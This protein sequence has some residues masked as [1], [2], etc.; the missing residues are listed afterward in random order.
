MFIWVICIPEKILFY[1]ECSLSLNISSEFLNESYPKDLL[2]NQQINVSAIIKS[3]CI[4]NYTLTYQWRI[5]KL[6]SSGNDTEIQIPYNPSL[7]SLNLKIPKDTLFYGIYK[8]RLEANLTVDTGYIKNITN[9]FSN[10]IDALVRIL[11]SGMDIF[12]L[13]NYLDSIKIGQNQ[14]LEFQP[15]LYSYDY[16][17][18]AKYDSVKFNFYCY[19]RNKSENLT[20]L[21]IKNFSL[22]HDIYNYSTRLTLNSE[23]FTETNQFELNPGN[24]VLK[25]LSGGL[26]YRSRRIY[27][28]LT[29]LNY[30]GVQF[31]QFVKVDVVPAP[32]APRLRLECKIP[33]LCIPSFRS[34]RVNPENQLAIASNCFDGCQGSINIIYT[35]DIYM[36][37]S[38]FGGSWQ[39][40]SQTIKTKYLYGLNGKE[41]VISKGFFDEYPNFFYWKIELMMLALYDIEGDYIDVNTRMLISTIQKPYNGSCSI[42]PNEGF[43][44][45]TD[46]SIECSN[47][48]DT[49]GFIADYS[50]Y[51]VINSSS[52]ELQIPLGS[53]S[54][55]MLKLKLPEGSKT[56]DYKLRIRIFISNDLG[57]TNEFEIPE[58]VYVIQKPGFMAVFTNQI[59]DPVESESLIN[60]LFKRNPIDASKNLL[61]LTLMMVSPINDNETNSTNT[62]TNYT[63]PVNANTEMKSIFIDV[64]STLPVKDLKSIKTVS[65]VISKL[66]ENTNEVTSQAASVVLDKNQELTT[67]LFKYKDNT[68]FG[69][70]KQASDN[71]IDSAASSL[72]VLGDP[73]NNETT[74]SSIESLISV[75]QIFNNLLDISSVHLGLNQESEVNTQSINLKFIKTDLNVVNKNISLENG[76][77]KLPDSFTSTELNKQFII[78]T[79]SMPKPIIGQ[80]GIQVNISDS[81]FVSL[82]FFNTENNNE[83]PIDNGN[84]TQQYFEVRLKRNS[85][86]IKIPDFQIINTSN[87]TMPLDKTIFFS[88]NVTNPNSSIHVQIKP[89]NVSKAIIIL[90]KFNENPSFKLKVYDL[91]KIFCPNDL[92]IYNG[93]EFYQFFANMS[94]TT[95]YWNNSY[96][97]VIFRQLSDDELKDY[98]ENGIKDKMS[99]PSILNVENPDFKLSDFTFR[100]FTS[101]CYFI[102]KTS[103]N[104]SSL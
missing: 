52:K 40:V 26:R 62:T 10:E 48:I 53:N 51:A 54:S 4:N 15:A 55:G 29:V 102:D 12:S 68:S 82:S 104:W 71:I 11:P 18:I 80:N 78:Q 94:T 22:D 81:S 58:D 13:E 28:F 17:Q 60:D 44:L 101:G 76:D 91:F 65:L 47:W 98:C 41:M 33:I 49:G 6:N 50:F 90:I 43:A 84:N 57:A 69:Q 64:A 20:F 31:Y 1:V 72:I 103:G 34:I 7:K 27:V 97:G 99:L 92:M 37:N 77:F 46:F 73:Q 74:N 85:R 21:K 79:F 8:L 75:S 87:I 42:Q 2:R 63:I 14:S 86:N 95:N 39:T 5:L 30:Y 66:T 70:I 100:V 19:V 61:S 88:F 16:D 32:R 56:N 35:F 38:G 96:V 93:T 9:V 3:E 25:I 89:E 59:L 83:V 36:S 23:C 24:N 67:S 45:M